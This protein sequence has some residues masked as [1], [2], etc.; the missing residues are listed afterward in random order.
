M[1]SNQLLAEVFMGRVTN[2][3]EL[4]GA[5]R[6]IIIVTAQPGDGLRSMVEAK[7][8]KGAELPSNTRSMT[9]ATQIAKVVSQLPGAIGIIAPASFNDSVGELHV[10]EA[11]AQPLI[12]VTMGAETTEV[13]RV[14]EAV[15]AVGNSRCTDMP[16]RSEPKVPCNS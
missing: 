6:E 2:W 8:L 7:L 12:L 9:N 5:D 15:I 11:I 3:K 14:I 16:M 4:G 1:L 10:D 13:H